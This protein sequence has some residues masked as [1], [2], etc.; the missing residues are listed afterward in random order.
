MFDNLCF[1][2]HKGVFVVG[3]SAETAGGGGDKG[4][5]MRLKYLHRPGEYVDVPALGVP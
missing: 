3:M 2:M 5:I 4:D 1:P